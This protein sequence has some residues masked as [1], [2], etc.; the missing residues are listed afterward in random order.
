MTAVVLAGSALSLATVFQSMHG[1]AEG[2]GSEQAEAPSLASKRGITCA[3]SAPAPWLRIN[4]SILGSSPHLRPMRASKHG[5][6]RLIF[7]IG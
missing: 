7:V 3:A 6:A 2:A 1:R 5:R 4:G